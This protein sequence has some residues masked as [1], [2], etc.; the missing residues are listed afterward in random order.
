MGTHEENSMQQE[1]I[2]SIAKKV[3]YLEKRQAK[4][5]ELDLPALPSKVKELETKIADTAK[6]Q[7]LEN[8]KQLE[9][10]DKQLSGF[11]GKINAMPKEIP[12]KYNVQFDTKA[13][14]VIKLILSL[15]LAAMILTGVV[16]ALLVEGN[17]IKN[18]G[19]KYKIVKGF[20]PEI[21]D[22]I[23]SAYIA[24]RDT[25]IKN[26]EMNIEHQKLVSE[27]EAKARET[28]EESKAAQ[29][30]LQQLKGG[31]GATNSDK[32]SRNKWNK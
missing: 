22:Q 4:I 20:Y 32:K 10:F 7:T 29:K 8:T 15:V 5:E 31:A 3:T 23:D 17:G 1:I 18:D 12:V 19:N 2:D 16:V 6:M 25:L 21:A 13:K 27:A 14:F 24:N 28:R 9:R 26:A 30:Q 11:D